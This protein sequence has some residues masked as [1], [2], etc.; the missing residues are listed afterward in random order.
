MVVALIALVMATAGTGIAATKVLIKSSK[1]VGHHVIKGI[2]IA[3][4]TVGQAN[5]APGVRNLLLQ[6]AAGGGGGVNAVGSGATEVFRKQGPTGQ[7]VGMAGRVA[8]MTAVPPGVY[9]FQAKTVIEADVPDPGVLGRLLDPQ[10]VSAGACMLSAGGDADTSL[11]P[12]ATIGTDYPNTL[13]MQ[14]TRTLTQPTN[15]TLDC[16]ATKTPWKTSNSTIIAV[17]VSGAPKTAV[18]G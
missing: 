18:S 9:V 2:N 7:A 12:I 15:V 10:N 6:S 16:L 4:D 3:N 13:Y 1:Q 5:L 11:G 8:T 14:V 17:K